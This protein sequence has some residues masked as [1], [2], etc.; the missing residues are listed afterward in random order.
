MCE[1]T[2]TC[3]APQRGGSRATPCRH[4]RE[5]EAVAG[6][7]SLAGPQQPLLCLHERPAPGS[8]ATRG[9]QDACSAHAA[10]AGPPG[11]SCTVQRHEAQ[12]PEGRLPPSMCDSGTTPSVFS[13]AP[14]YLPL[15]LTS[16]RRGF[17]SRAWRQFQ[18]LSSHPSS[19]T[20]SPSASGLP[21]SLHIRKLPAGRS[22]IE[23][24]FAEPAWSPCQGC[25][26]PRKHL[27]S[28]PCWEH[29]VP[30]A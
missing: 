24:Y 18:G 25:L 28:V 30:E 2:E 26:P 23:G 9:N 4:P 11:L 27:F 13:L 22:C 12:L 10:L 5:R 19:I 3:F 17:E 16:S 8:S 21:R 6:G 20:R 14:S 29:L 1:L 15:P 7:G